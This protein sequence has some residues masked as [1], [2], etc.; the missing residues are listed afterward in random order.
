[1]V[2]R[3]AAP[4]AL[5]AAL[6]PAGPAA[7]EPPHREY[8]ALELGLGYNLLAE[9]DDFTRRAQS[10]DF[11]PAFLWA[12]QTELGLSF[13][14]L[15]ALALVVSYA[16]IDKGHMTRSGFDTAEGGSI[17]TPSQSLRWTS[18]LLALKLRAQWPVKRWLRPY[19]Q[20]GPGLGIA[21][22]EFD[23]LG[24]G[25]SPGIEVD[26]RVDFAPGLAADVGCQLMPVPVFGFY[27]AIGMTYAPVLE[28]S[29]GDARQPLAGHLTAGVRLAWSEQ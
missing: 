12:M 2:R 11:R 6:W 1:M 23:A 19:V 21:R 17:D 4:L 8:A 22:T 9:A 28:T 29:L 16:R 7:A 26:E 14:L 27:V 3:A 18:G 20:A 5:C 25:E 24:L 13:D 10:F 15:P